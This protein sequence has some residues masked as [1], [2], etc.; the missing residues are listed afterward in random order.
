MLMLAASPHPHKLHPATQAES[1]PMAEG[2]E[3]PMLDIRDASISYGNFAVLRGIDLQVQKG[4]V[5]VI[6]GPSGSGKSTLLRSV[7]LI[8][9]LDSGSIVLQGEHELTR[10]D[11][12]VNW[13]R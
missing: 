4:E 12:D 10:A 13:V 1:F 2:T 8:Q 9:P 6:I 11:I 3:K 7:N 5:V